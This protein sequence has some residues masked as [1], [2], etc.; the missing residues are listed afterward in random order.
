M[1]GILQPAP[2]PSPDDIDFLVLQAIARQYERGTVARET[3]RE[4]V[5]LHP[6][7]GPADAE[8]DAALARLRSVGHVVARGGRYAVTPAVAAILPRTKAGAVSAA[9][10]SWERFRARLAGAPPRDG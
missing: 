7:A 4:A 6:G 9:A 10:A 8:L 3:L 5:H 2:V 1:L